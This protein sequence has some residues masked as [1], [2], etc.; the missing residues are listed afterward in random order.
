MGKIISGK[1]V[2]FTKNLYQN[3]KHG[4]QGIKFYERPGN[5]VGKCFKYQVLILT[6]LIGKFHIPVHIMHHKEA[7]ALRCCR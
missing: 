1:I 7:I 4:K 6:I 2:V 5:F 3:D